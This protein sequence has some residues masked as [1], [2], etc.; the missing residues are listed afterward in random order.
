MIVRYIHWILNMLTLMKIYSAYVKLPTCSSPV[1][2]EIRESVDFWPYFKDCIGAIDG[3]HIPA[4]APES[5]W[6]R[7]WNWKGQVSQNI[8]VWCAP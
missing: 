1:P 4:F 3:S 8:L 2:D 6:T 5:M 7:F